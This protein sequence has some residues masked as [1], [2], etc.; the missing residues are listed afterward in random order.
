MITQNHTLIRRRTCVSALSEEV[1][2]SLVYNAYTSFPQYFSTFVGGF[3]TC[4]Q[5]HLRT[6]R[7]SMR[8]SSADFVRAG[9]RSKHPSA[10]RYTI[11]IYPKVTEGFLCQVI[12][13]PQ[14][15][16]EK[17]HDVFFRSQPAGEK[18][19]YVFSCS[20]PAGEKLHYVFSRSQPA[21]EKLHYVISRPQPAGEKLHYVISRSQPAGGKIYDVIYYLFHI[22]L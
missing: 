1:R 16:G 12:S 22:K 8:I 19:H 13:R 2:K 6:R 5:P 4:A 7:H 9:L 17:L 15:A 14:P 20:Q 11:Y 10:Q 3:S 21:G 18:L